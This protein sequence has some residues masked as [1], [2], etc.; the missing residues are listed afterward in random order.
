[1]AMV[2]RRRVRLR[3]ETARGCGAPTAVAVD[4]CLHA[5]AAAAVGR[6]GSGLRF[7]AGPAP[8]VFN[9]MKMLPERGW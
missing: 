9:Q 3:P 8:R 6:F 7:G 1:M 5:L 4:E 2:P